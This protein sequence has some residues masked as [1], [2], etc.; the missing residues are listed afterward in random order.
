MLCQYKLHVQCRLLRTVTYCQQNHT[1]NY[2]QDNQ[3]AKCLSTRAALVSSSLG[4]LSRSCPGTPSDII[5]IGLNV[6]NNCALFTHNGAQVGENFIQFFDTLLNILNLCF[7]FLNQILLI[8]KLMLVEQFLLFLS[9]LVLKGAVILLLMIYQ[10]INQ[11]LLLFILRIFRLNHG[12]SLNFGQPP[13]H[14][15]KLFQRRFELTFKLALCKPLRSSNSFLALEIDNQFT[16]VFNLVADIVSKRNSP[17]L[18]S[19]AGIRFNQ[20]LEM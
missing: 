6:I 13:L 17:F 3:K 18:N 11:I 19:V 16:Q 1:E 8:I 10:V 4:K 15:L 2:Q 20:G 5:N 14:L 12:L 9:L 7:T